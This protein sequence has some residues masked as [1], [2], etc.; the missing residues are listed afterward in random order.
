MATRPRDGTC[1]G[2]VDRGYMRQLPSRRYALGSRLIPLGEIAGATL[3]T[4]ARP[5]L[6]ELV[7]RLG[8]SP[9]LAVLD[10]DR[11]TYIGQV[12]SGTPCARSPRWGPG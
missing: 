9:N 6:A 5:I 8:E 2:V 11:V 3:G 1:P 10:G 4:W 12:P 7:D